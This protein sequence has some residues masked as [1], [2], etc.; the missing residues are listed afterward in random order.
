MEMRSYLACILLSASYVGVGLSQSD[1]LIDLPQANVTAGD[2][3]E[4]KLTLNTPA[5]CDTLVYLYFV[6]QKI[7]AQFQLNSV[8]RAG[9]TTAN[10]VGKIPRDVLADEYQSGTREINPCPE[11]QNGIDIK[12]PIKVLSVKAFPNPIQFPNTAGLQL[13]VTQKQF[14]DTKA[15]EL[16]SLRSKLDTG[17]EKY[18]AE[19]PPLR[20]FLAGI[21]DTAEDELTLTEKQYREKIQKPKEK[22]PAFFAD[23]HAQY[24]ALRVNLKAPI[25]GVG[26][27]Y[28][29]PKAVLLYVQLKKRPPSENLSNTLSPDALATNMLIKDNEAVYEYISNTGQITFKARITS[30]PTG[31][32]I[33]YK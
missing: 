1:G 12:V 13:T 27:T 18:S 24:Q 25:P 22:L 23:F 9:Q 31:A 16:Y 17:L 5:G 20:E 10:I 28:A 29:Q 7:H 14:F 4:A 11:Y 30:Y 21:V 6:D 3:I 2:Q 19:L 26:I 33:R 32:R 15:A 8:I